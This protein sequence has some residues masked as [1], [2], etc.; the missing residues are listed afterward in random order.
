[1][2]G[3]HIVKRDNCPMWKRICFYLAAVLGNYNPSFAGMGLMSYS[4][5]LKSFL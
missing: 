4:P 2:M 3:F 1:M 5:Q